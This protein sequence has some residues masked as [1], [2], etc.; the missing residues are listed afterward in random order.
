MVVYAVRADCRVCRHCSLGVSGSG[1]LAPHRYAYGA[2]AL[3]RVS[4][5]CTVGSCFLAK[6]WVPHDR[7]RVRRYTNASRQ[8]I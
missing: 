5:V 8:V 4:C 7:T 1:A 3:A 2:A 6:L